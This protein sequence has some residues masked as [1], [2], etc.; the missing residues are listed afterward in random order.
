MPL[1]SGAMDSM[2]NLRR[3]LLWI[4]GLGGVV[5]GVAMFVLSG[6]LSEWYRLPRDFLLFMGA[7][8]LAY[9]CYSLP[10]AK[11]S[12]RPMSLIMLLAVANLAWGVACLRWAVVFRDTASFFGLAH[13]VLEGLYVGGLGCLEWRWREL[14]QSA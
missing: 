8:N 11:R 10:L 5:V 2:M 9:G 14:L 12:R 7:V 3:N 4:D 13:F 6:W 1:R